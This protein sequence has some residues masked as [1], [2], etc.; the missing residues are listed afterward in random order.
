[1][2]ILNRRYKFSILKEFS[3]KSEDKERDKGI[4]EYP[5]QMNWFGESLY[6]EKFSL[7][8]RWAT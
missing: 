6:Y 5:R 2:R 7:G 8:E 3:F 1:M 4:N